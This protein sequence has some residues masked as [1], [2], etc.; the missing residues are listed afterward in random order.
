MILLSPPY[1]KKPTVGSRQPYFRFSLSC[2]ILLH[3]I[4]LQHPPPPI[5]AS[6]IA[7]PLKVKA[8]KITSVKTTA[9]LKMMTFLSYVNS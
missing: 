7:L 1:F 5:P 6:P 4:L 9:F 8:I 2:I 3:V